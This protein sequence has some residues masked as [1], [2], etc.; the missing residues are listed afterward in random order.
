[1]TVRVSCPFCNTVSTLSETPPSGRVAC[2]RCGDAFPVQGRI[3]EADAASPTGNDVAANGTLGNGLSTSQQVVQAVQ[4]SSQAPA[5]S[6]GQAGRRQRGQWS[7]VRATAVALSMGLIGLTIGLGV[8]AYNGGF[9]P[10]GSP[11]GSD[12]GPSALATPPSQL[13]GL[14]FLPANCNVV[15]ALQPGPILVY[16]DRTHQDPSDLLSKVGVPVSVL[17]TLDRIGVP[18]AQVDHIAGGVYVPDADLTELRVAL[19]L[20]L[21]GPLADES[22]FLKQLKARRTAAGG[23][24]HY[25]VELSGLPC[26]LVKASPTVWVAGLSDQDLKSVESGGKAQLSANLR[27]TLDQQLPPDAAAW[28][29]TDSVRWAD[30]KS[31]QF[32]VEQFGK[33]EWLDVLKKGQAVVAGM[34]FAD[35]PRSRLFVRCVDTASGEKLRAYFRAKA[36]GEGVRQGGA[37]EWAMLDIPG[38]PQGSVA[39]LK[40]FVEDA[41]K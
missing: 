40:S 18:L 4:P 37:G 26:E 15:F 33:K 11:P 34:T 2:R 9:R 21:R 17:A 27:E 31:V 10:R 5:R 28:I 24:T 36:T 8:Y 39:I 25:D 1:M 7:V 38:D 12:S 19:A 16:A 22:K 32:A 23:K 35:P 29:A 30:K 14:G 6:S 13:S 3:V 20:V 41:G